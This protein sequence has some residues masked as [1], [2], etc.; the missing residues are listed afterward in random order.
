[1]KI[2]VII[3]TKNEPLI[4]QLTKEI[5]QYLAKQDHEIIVVDKSEKRPKITNAKLILQQSDGLGNAVLEGLN[6][7]EG[8]AIVIMDGDF[9]HN[10]NDINKLVKGLDKFDIVI[11]S[12]FIK[13]GKTE[14][15][16]HRRI[17]SYIFRKIASNMLHLNIEDSMPGFAA[18][19]REVFNNLTINPIGYKINMEIMFKGMKKGYKVCEVPIIFHPRRAGKSKAGLSMGGLKESFRILRYIFELKTG[20]R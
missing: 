8:D 7:A 20:L 1:M 5:H 2:S 17:I 15:K 19:K 11:G 12:R 16:T 9:S 3:P 4:Q 18:I 10:P 13:G 14:D 6:H